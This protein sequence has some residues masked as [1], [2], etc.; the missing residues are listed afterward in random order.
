[1]ETNLSGWGGKI[2]LYSGGVWY[3]G[4]FIFKIISCNW[5]TERIIF[6][7]VLLHVRKLVDRKQNLEEVN[8]ISSPNVEWC[9]KENLSLLCL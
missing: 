6:F 9:P 4:H 3:L 1:M 2:G 5:F 7:I 8:R